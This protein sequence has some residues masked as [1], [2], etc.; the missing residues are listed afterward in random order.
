[1]AISQI[2]FVLVITALTT[3]CSTVPPGFEAPRLTVVSLSPKD[4][5]FFEQQYDVELRIQNPN[6]N[7]LSLTGLRFELEL[8]DR[9]FAT[10]MSG[11]TI[12]VPRFDSEIIHARVISTAASLIRQIQEVRRKG[13][14]K[15]SYRMRGTAFVESPG[16]L[17]VPFEEQGEFD[18]KPVVAPSTNGANPDGQWRSLP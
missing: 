12:I 18:F 14:S 16:R 10:G 11:E 15:M 3:A 13:I 2:P 8:N 9:L 17:T 6:E 7:Q 5:T 4:V 1:M